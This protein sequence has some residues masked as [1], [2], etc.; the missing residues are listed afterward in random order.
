MNSENPISM[1]VISGR[2]ALNCAKN[3]ANT[4][5]TKMLTIT[6]PIAIAAT[7]NIG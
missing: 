6:S 5:M 1:R 2:G 7:T 3:L 4:G